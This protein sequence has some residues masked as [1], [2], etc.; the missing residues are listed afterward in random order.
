MMEDLD[1]IPSNEILVAGFTDYLGR[2]RHLAPGTI[3]C[4][5]VDLA[6]FGDFL[7]RFNSGHRGETSFLATTKDRVWQFRDYL[8]QAGFASATIDR[9]LSALAI[10][11]KFCLN[12]KHIEA[13][14]TEGVAR[15]RKPNHPSDPPTCPETTAVEKILRHLSDKERRATFRGA[16]DL[17]MVELM[18]NHG[19]RVNE[20]VALNLDD[21]RS[22]S[23]ELSVGGKTKSR[24]TTRLT[25]R[26]S[27]SLN[28]YL[29]HRQ[30]LLSVHGTNANALFV[31]RRGGRMSQRN[32]WRRLERVSQEAETSQINGRGLRHLYVVTALGT[33]VP[34]DQLRCQLGCRAM[35]FQHYGPLLSINR[36]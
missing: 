1:L 14:P 30:D 22:D 23:H 5:S 6:S 11:F 15:A 35:N 33:G 31:N 36:H 9:K 16:P 29:R 2:E 12:R 20:V 13:N 4:Y 25:D 26:E 21:W 3:H 28:G 10:F 34:P 17:L 32:V 8:I 24:R 18:R 7:G 27:K 19:L